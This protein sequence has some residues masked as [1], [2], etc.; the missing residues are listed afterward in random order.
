MKIGTSSTANHEHRDCGDFQIYHKG[1]LIGSSGAYSN[2]GSVHD[3]A[4]YKQTVAK[5]SILVFNPNMPDNGI[6][7]YSGGQ[8]IDDECVRGS[9]D[10]LEDWLASANY[11][12]AK[13]LYS[14]YKTEKNKAEEEEY[15]YSYIGGDITRAYD[16]ET[17]SEVK[18]HMVCFST[19]SK[20]N[21]LVF[22]IF[23][24]ITSIS[25]DYK[26]S[27]LFHT[28]NTPLITEF[29][30]KPCAVI[31]NLMSRLYVQ[32]LLSEVDYTFVGGRDNEYLVRGENV[33]CFFPERFEGLN[34][35]Y[36]TEGGLGRL[37][38]S[39]RRPEKENSFITVMY[40]G[41]HTDCSPYLNL[42]NNILQPYREAKELVG[43]STVGA[44]ILGNA[45]VF[46]ADGEYICRDFELEIPEDVRRCLIFGLK[47]GR[48]QAADGG[49]YTVT[50]SECMAEV[51]V[52]N[53]TAL[54]MKYLG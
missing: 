30:G 29:N 47:G 27:L 23:D 53:A 42:D 1:M 33:S 11:N 40:V 19:D 50:D 31:T 5:N 2:Y 7:K 9:I 14:G 37:E 8:R 46:S 18:R 17:V 48:W 43:E 24:K 26:K 32:S 36:N 22:V 13:L 28:Q 44:A 4:Y 35:V 41:P 10:N 38:I 54:K 21:P 49:I 45:V 34:S 12:R 39:P 16:A 20:V 25:E 15:C 51:K 6:W 3:Y 52:E